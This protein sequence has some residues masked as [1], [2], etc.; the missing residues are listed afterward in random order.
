MNL[1]EREGELRAVKSLRAAFA[2]A[3]GKVVVISG[4]VATG[5]STLLRAVG[6]AVSESGAL[7]LGAV[8]SR[9]ERTLPLGVLEQIFR[10]PDLPAGS[11]ERATRWLAA[12]APAAPA[13]EAVPRGAGNVP[14][15]VLR[16]LWEVMSEL[17]ERRPVVIG[18]DDVQYAD[19]PSL[20]CLLYLLRRL[21]SARLHVVFGECSHP[22]AA[23]ALLQSEFL[24]EP[25]FRRIRLQP[26]SAAGVARMLAAQLDERAAQDLAPAFHEASAGYPPLVQALIDDHRTGPPAAGGAFA[27]AVLRF[28]HR[29]EPPI[30][31]VA[32]ELAVLDR[33]ASVPLLGRLLDL[34]AA[35]TLQALN[36]LTIAEVVVNGRF[37]HRAFQTAIL[38]GTPPSALR[39][40]HGRIADLLHDEGA[41]AE[42]V[43]AH[44][45]VSD[46]VEAPW[47]V[48]ILREA[49]D[50]ALTRD[51]VGAGIRYLR[52]AHQACDED[53]RRVVA[54]RL[55]NAEWRVDPAMVLR[56]LHEFDRAAPG[57]PADV[58]AVGTDLPASTTYLLWHGR[59]AEALRVAGGLPGPGD[60]A[61]AL[62]DL[63]TSRLWGAYLYP[64]LFKPDAAHRY[65]A[66]GGEPASA[67]L[68]PE[69]EGAD[70][71]A[72]DLALGGRRRAP[73]AAESILQRSRLNHRTLVPLTAALAVLTYN[74]R[75][76]TACTW[77]EGLVAEAATRRSPTW[78][79]LFAAQLA[80]I[81]VRRGNLRA[82]GTHAEAALRLIS[83]EGW[84]VAVGLPVAAR[85][86][87]A[88]AMGDARQAEAA[89]DIP[90]PEA[91]FQ[92]R[93]GA[94]Y[95]YARG[96]HHLA[97]GRVHAALS[98]FCACGRLMGDWGIDLP[99][100]EPWRAGAIEACLL[101]GEPE[102]AGRLADEQL[103][104]LGPGHRRARG[105][106]LRSLAATRAV[107]A[108]PALLAE[109]VDLLR[110]SG[111]R[112]GLA[113]ALEDQGRAA[114]LLG[115]PGRARAL[116]REA[117]AIAREC[118]AGT[119]DQA[120]AADGGGDRPSV[121]EPG[122]PP[123]RFVAE[124]SDA[125]LR[126]AALAAAGHTNR[127]ISEKL[128]ITV[129]TVEQ[130][131]TKVYRKLKVGRLDLLAV[132]Q[133]A[134]EAGHRAGTA[135]G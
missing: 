15:P 116:T 45:V 9:V 80:L 57:D 28:L 17:V 42:E 71:L 132:L 69:L 134:E 4:G 10:S 68:N 67:V 74:D 81:H 36:T 89:L 83:P 23:S 133:F 122:T 112:L 52:A 3:G 43:A 37:R 121:P 78:H 125:E 25:F 31:E 2:Q 53:Q 20:Q 47:V 12:G 55:V 16:G 26:L 54:A 93:M 27:R 114:E 82:A 87:A 62:A 38:D 103:A 127:E 49:A 106:A 50:H 86:L 22:K 40:A 77:C 96:R 102:E 60:G 61:D 90:V 58:P 135:G 44:I 63:A 119:L 129:S 100:V 104:L 123:L 72:A 5:K 108:R 76:G 98:D 56:R 32:R 1:I 94:H 29:Y 13:G 14:P 118:G 66:A 88:T 59:V 107:R 73:A 6:D 85:V 105:L 117:H 110:G 8:A 120:R 39:T 84:G 109:A 131:L 51:E 24:R 33:P 11:A 92:C 18:V 30:M 126:V 7:F 75:L 111:D 41:P 95:L 65:G 35:S 91:M 46:R 113:R 130:H 70:L 101:L 21:R 79:A 115:E 124:L 19:A 97:T 34:D 64:Q 128:Y 99:A 48:P